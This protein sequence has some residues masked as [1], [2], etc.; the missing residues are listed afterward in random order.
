M[1]M[2]AISGRR[3]QSG[4]VFNEYSAVATQRDHRG[5][6]DGY[7]I[8]AQCQRFCGIG[9]A[10][11]AARYDE[12]NFTVHAEF[13]QCVDGH[14]YR[15]QRWNADVFD[16]YIL[17]GGGAALHAVDDYDIRAR[18][19]SQCD[20][21]ADSRCPDL[22]EYRDLPVGDLT[23]FLNLDFQV[24]G[25]GP[26]G[27]PAGAALVDVFWQVTHFGHAR[28]DLVAEQHAATTGFGTLADDDLQGIR[29]SDIIGV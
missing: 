16:E 9:T 11:Y 29:A 27:M 28:G 7:G 10:A 4:V 19:D 22:D 3:T 25:S 15:R 8:S 1:T 6:A 20:V 26:V 21:V 13:L 18:L 5:A 24:I 17:R 12:L 14:A 23:Q 2:M